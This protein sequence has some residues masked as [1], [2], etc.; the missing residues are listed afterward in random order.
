MYLTIK[1]RLNLAFLMGYLAR[2]MANPGP[3]HFKLLNKV[4][5]YLVNTLDLGL[6][7][8]LNSNS[9]N[10]YV[11]ADQ[12][13]DIG[14]RRSTIG[15]IFLYKG[16]PISWNSKLQR[17]IALSSYEA[18]YMAIK[19]AIKEQ[20]YINAI[21]SELKPILAGTAIECLNIYTDLNSAIELAKNPIYHARTKHIDIQYHYIR[22]CIQKGVSKLVW[23]PIAGQLADGLTKAISSDKWTQFI[24]GIGLKSL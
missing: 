19:E 21:L 12:G 10:C 20:Q 14:T 13:G 23:V 1:T 11:D 22:E 15:Y 17:T 9:I 8:H 4:W 7:S 5:K 18:K 6:Q 24:T 16:T 3:V 2:Y